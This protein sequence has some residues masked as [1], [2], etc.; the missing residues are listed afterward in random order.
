MRNTLTTKTAVSPSGVR[1]QT[2]FEESDLI[3][4]MRTERIPVDYRDKKRDLQFKSAL[5]YLQ[6][7]M[8]PN[9]HREKCFY[10]TTDA[11]FFFSVVCMVSTLSELRSIFREA[12]ILKLAAVAEEKSRKGNWRTLSC[13]QKISIA[14]L[15]I[16]SA[17]WIR[18]SFE[19]P[20][21]GAECLGEASNAFDRDVADHV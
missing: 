16:R 5:A 17:R 21:R 18:R 14:P 9:G 15:G 1:K 19:N 3:E 13:R 4:L 7:G 6:A 11:K 12:Q 10:T 8:I 2:L 20:Y